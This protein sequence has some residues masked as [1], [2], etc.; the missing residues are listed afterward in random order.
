M[1]Q[2]PILATRGWNNYELIDSGGFEKLERFGNIITI[3]PEPQAIWEKDLPNSDWEKR[4]HIRFVGSSPR[5]GKW[6][7]LKPCP[8]RW[9]LEYELNSQKILTFQLARTKF[10]HIGLFPEQSVNWERLFQALSAMKSPE[11]SVLNAFAYTGGASLA[12]RAAGASVTHVDSIKQVVS[13]A[14]SNLALSKM[15][16]IRWMVEDAPTFLNR[17]LRRG[18]SYNAIVLDPPAFGHGPNGE[19]WILEKQIYDLVDT[20]IQLLNP[21]EAIL[22]V[23]TYS[24][25]FSSILVYNVLKQLALPSDLIESAELCLEDG[26]GKRLPLGVVTTLKRGF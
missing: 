3:R 14:A 10:K 18:K 6:M 21:T 7:E 12:G 25:G 15:D 8:E 20:A 17:E 9:T 13:W 11:K 5:D 16:G 23:N 26:F 19:S 1:N 22:I 2:I 4:A 24:L